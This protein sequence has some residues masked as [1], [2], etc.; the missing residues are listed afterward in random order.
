MFRNILK[1]ML[2]N[3][4]KHKAFSLINVM[5]LAIGMAC[6]LL[7]LMFVSDELSYDKYNVRGDSIYRFNSHSTIGGT[8]RHFA[9]S[10]AARELGWGQ[11]AVGK[12][13]VDFTADQSVRY[14][15]TGVVRDFHHKSLKK[16]SLLQP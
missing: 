16:S 11:A 2:R 15:V 10:P 9:A 12:E 3:L 6:C 1:I 8:T 5:G 7:I 14:R 13:V 4:R